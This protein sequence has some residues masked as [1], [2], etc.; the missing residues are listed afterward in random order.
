MAANYKA[1]L[2]GCFG[3]PVAENPTGVMQEAGF[4]APQVELDQV[5]VAIEWYAKVLELS[6]G[7]L[8]PPV[9]WG[10]VAAAAAGALRFGRSEEGTHVAR[11]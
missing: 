7:A 6:A 5:D 10:L 8:V 11:T 3:Q 9:L 4:R 1:E 2:V